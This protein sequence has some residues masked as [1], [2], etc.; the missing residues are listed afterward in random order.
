M[1]DLHLPSHCRN[2]N[3]TVQTKYKHLATILTCYK[4]KGFKCNPVIK[5][6]FIKWSAWTLHLRKRKKRTTRSFF[7]FFLVRNM[8]EVA[9]KRGRLQ[10]LMMFIVCSVYGGGGVVVCNDPFNIDLWCP[11]YS[12]SELWVCASAPEQTL[13]S[14]SSFAAS[15]L[16]VSLILF[17]PCI[18]RYFVFILAF[19]SLVLIHFQGVQ[20]WDLLVHTQPLHCLLHH[21]HGAHGRVGL[22]AETVDG[23]TKRLCVW[24]CVWVFISARVTVSTFSLH[25]NHYLQKRDKGLLHLSVSKYW[26]LPQ[27]PMEITHISFS[28]FHPQTMHHFRNAFFKNSLYSIYKSRHS[29]KTH[30]ESFISC[31]DKWKR[32][33]SCEFFA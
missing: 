16:S 9:V 2:K 24:F 28:C 14:L 21:P 26:R 20:L 19:T 6:V 8:K 32:I 33:F 18:S 12:G 7:F 27:M 15:A 17:F 5:C 11:A 1:H 10:G 4:L 22:R 25:L 23:S 13:T 31:S 3:R 29:L 30:K